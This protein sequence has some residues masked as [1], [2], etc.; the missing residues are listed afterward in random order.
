MDDGSGEKGFGF[1]H[2]E[3]GIPGSVLARFKLISEAVRSGGES[4]GF[5][6]DLLLARFAP[7]AAMLDDPIGQSLL[8]P[9]VPACFFRLD[10]FVTKDFFALGLEL[11]IERGV[12][13]EIRGVVRCH[14]QW[15]VTGL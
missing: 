1:G 12:L 8:E 9:N 6:G 10:P 3:K 4:V 5:G 7:F 15:F 2:L 11:A 14:S 13:K